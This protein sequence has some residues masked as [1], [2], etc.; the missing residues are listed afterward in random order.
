VELVKAALK[1]PLTPVLF[2]GTPPEVVIHRLV[3]FRES[4]NH[5]SPRIPGGNKKKK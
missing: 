1:T 5:R 2:K 4:S 3:E